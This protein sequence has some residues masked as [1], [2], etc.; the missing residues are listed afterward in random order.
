MSAEGADSPASLPPEWQLY[1]AF[2]VA[3]ASRR[4]NPDSAEL[5]DRVSL[6][7]ARLVPV[8]KAKG[9]GRVSP[10]EI[11]YFRMASERRHTRK[12][13]QAPGSVVPNPRTAEAIS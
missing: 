8:L 12:P 3:S 11:R 7:A 10:R 5:S 6:R 13:R 4:N 9:R 2:S 1:T